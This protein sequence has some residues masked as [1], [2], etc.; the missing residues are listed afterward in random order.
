MSSVE[1]VS[2]HFRYSPSGSP[3]TKPDSDPVI[4]GFIPLLPHFDSTKKRHFSILHQTW[5]HGPSRIFSISCD[6]HDNL[7]QTTTDAALFDCF[8]ESIKSIPVSELQSLSDETFSR[9]L[10]THHAF[11]KT[12]RSSQQHLS[13]TYPSSSIAIIGREI[14]LENPDSLT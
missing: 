3:C 2:I 1:K 9:R 4:G 5:M 8:A 6:V 12:S 7:P 10:P 11:Q 14:S 13:N